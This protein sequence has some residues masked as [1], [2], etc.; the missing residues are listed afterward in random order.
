MS[1]ARGGR[2]RKPLPNLPGIGGIGQIG[3]G[4]GPYSGLR[5]RATIRS[6][7][8]PEPWMHTIVPKHPTNTQTCL[9]TTAA[10]TTA[11]TATATTGAII[12]KGR[13]SQPAGEGGRLTE[14]PLGRLHIARDAKGGSTTTA[15]QAPKPASAVN[16]GF[17]RI[18][19]WLR[20]PSNTATPGN[21][22]R[23]GTH[24]LGN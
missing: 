15:W 6:H 4:I 19:H 11:A 13:V 8:P 16:R 9:T 22:N 24:Q 12:P 17:K 1:A 23:A 20:P 2:P 21:N 5:R 18:W 7:G 10:A 14:T 3:P